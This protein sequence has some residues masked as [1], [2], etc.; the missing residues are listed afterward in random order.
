M[1]IKPIGCTLYTDKKQGVD[2]AVGPGEVIEIE[3]A[4]AMALIKA[5]KAEKAGKGEGTTEPKALSKKKREKLETQA[6]ESGL[7]NADELANLT[8]AELIALVDDKSGDDE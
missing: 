7:G 8:D 6:V 2:S 4:E 3:D 1:K 5:G